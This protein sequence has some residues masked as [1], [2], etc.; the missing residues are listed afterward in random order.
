MKKLVNEFLEHLEIEKNRSAKTLENYRRYLF[1]FL[2]VT[3][4]SSPSGITADAVRRYRIHLNRVKDEHGKQLKR[5]TQAY[6]VI[7]LRSFLKF[8]AKRD[9]ATLAAEKI[10]L[11]KNQERELEFL[12]AEEL[13]RLLKAPKGNDV[14]A[15]RDKAILETLFSTG[16]RVA[17]LCSLKTGDVNLDK[18]EFAVRGKGGKLRIVFLSADAERALRAYLAEREDIYEALFVAHRKGVRPS[19]AA[20]AT[21]TP[22]SV[23]RLIK[24][25][26]VMA[27]IVKKV[28]PHQLRHSF[29]TDLLHNG[30]DI[31][32]VQTMLGHASI[33]TTQIYTHYTDKR[34][35]EIHEKYHGKK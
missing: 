19:R 10:E 12:D 7:A 20:L 5:N 15:L 23:Q 16:L 8:L 32:S 35:K 14:A 31:R 26:A 30:A 2:D 25:Y 4:V 17:E 29:A 6:Y 13:A 1:N 34:L 33:T 21:L 18:R 27:G 24:K 11:P 9:I 22:R 28:T 3:G